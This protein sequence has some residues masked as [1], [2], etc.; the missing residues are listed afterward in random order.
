MTALS[1]VELAGGLLGIVGSIV[2]ALPA[3]AD[4]TNRN[5][6]DRLKGLESIKGA[7]VDDVARLKWL[8][9]DDILG[10]HRVHVHCAVWGSLFLVF[11]F[12]A[13]AVAGGIRLSGG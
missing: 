2:L 8:I 5:F 4:L 11:G 7:T 13:I 3:I 1:G 12:A 9:L 6:W 10:G